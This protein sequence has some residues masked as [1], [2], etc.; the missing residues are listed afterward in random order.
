[1][2]VESPLDFYKK[3]E[4]ALILHFYS[5]LPFDA[6]HYFMMQEKGPHQMLMSCSGTLSLQNYKN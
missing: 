5:V 6:L 1:M 2:R 4:R 3:K